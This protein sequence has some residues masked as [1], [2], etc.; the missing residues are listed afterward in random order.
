MKTTTQSNPLT[1][2]EAGQLAREIVA[3]IKKNQPN[4]IVGLNHAPWITDGESQLYWS[5]MPVDVLDLVWVQG[6]GDSDI[7]PNS[8]T[9][10]AATA[11]YAWLRK[12]TGLPIMAETSYGLPDRWTT[13]TADQI[14]AR[15]ANG[16]IGV[17]ENFATSL[18]TDA[19]TFAT[20]TSVS[21]SLNSTCN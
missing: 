11:N 8:N 13:A 3:A 14:N 12:K 4:A 5:N 7:F 6:A 19:K 9:T 10:N 2:P 20:A 16:V 21:A 17:L 18:W 1:G 15:I